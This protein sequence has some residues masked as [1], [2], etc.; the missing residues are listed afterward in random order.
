MIDRW[1]NRMIVK[2]AVGAAM[3]DRLGRMVSRA[4]Y[5]LGV[6]AVGHLVQLGQ[7]RNAFVRNSLARAIEVGAVLRRSAGIEDKTARLQS[8]T[9]VTGG[10]VLFQGEAVAADWKSSEPYTFRELTYRLKGHDAWAN[11]TAEIWVKN[12]HHVIWHNGTVIATSPDIISLLD[13]ETYRPLTTLGD[14]IPGRRVTVF[15]MKAL[16]P[17]WHTPAGHALLGPRHFGFDF[18][19]VDLF[20]SS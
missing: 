10:R 8:L 17:V 16:D 6:A 14:I 11:S 2:Q 3:V 5:G 12:E 13:P 15:G 18:D 19:P 1:G 9:A 20:A 4:A 7:V